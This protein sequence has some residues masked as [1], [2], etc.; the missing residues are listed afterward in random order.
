M[1]LRIQICF[2]LIIQFISSAIA[3]TNPYKYYSFS[4][5]QT[6][7]VIKGIWKDS[8]GYIWIATDLGV[9]TYDGTQTLTHARGLK[10]LYTKKFSQLPDGSFAVINDSGLQTVT[11]QND[12]I[13]FQDLTYRGVDLS[14]RM[15]YPKAIFVASDGWLWVGESNAVVRV[16]EVGLDR[17]FFGNNFNYHRSFS[18]AED[19][20]KNIWVAPY[21]GKLQVWNKTTSS[22]DSIAV[23]IPVRE[24]T[25]IVSVRGDYLLVGGVNGISMIKVDSDRNILESTFFSEIKGISTLK[26]AGDLVIIGTWDSGLYYFDY[27]SE[28]PT[29]QKFQEIEFNDIVD[30]YYDA[31]LDEIW[32]AGSENI[33]LL[34]RT[35]FVAFG[36]TGKYR[37]ES[38]VYDEKGDLFFTTGEDLFVHRKS[39]LNKELICPAEDVF[40]TTISLFQNQLWIGDQ[41]GRLHR[42]DEKRKKPVLVDSIP[43]SLYPVNHLNVIGNDLWIAGSPIGVMRL[44]SDFRIER[45][46]FGLATVIRKSPKGELFVGGNNA[47]NLLHVFDVKSKLFVDTKIAFEYEIEE[48]VRIEDIAFGPDGSIYL[49]SNEGVLVVERT[50]NGFISR[51]KLNFTLSENSLSCRALQWV[52]DDLWV[53]T[54]QGIY[55]YSPKGEIYFN[56]I[57]GLPSR[58]IKQRGFHFDGKILT[59]ATAQGMAKIEPAKV[60]FANTSSPVIE[61]FMVGDRPFYTQEMKDHID[62]LSNV[63]LSFRSFVYP[64]YDIQYQTRILGINDQWNSPSSNQIISLF[65][66]PRGKYTLEIRSKTVGYLWSNVTKVDFEVMDPWYMTWWAFVFF[67]VLAIAIVVISNKI[68]HYNLIGNQKKL[69]RLVEESTKEIEKHQEEIIE[70]KNRIIAQKEELLDKKEAV[71]KA[72]QAMTDTDLKYLKIRSNIE[73]SRSPRTRSISFKRMKRC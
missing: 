10:N 68:Y 59:V 60:N 25:S 19:A 54:N 63:E 57:S 27:K 37:I 32:V 44:T 38:F 11:R 45:F 12:S 49:A 66:I 56:T 53:G 28:K 72:Q 62:H 31:K 20:F 14:A 39:Q 46:N 9:L 52:G 69:K 21:S 43:A 13:L 2:I 35:P 30:L 48:N 4:N 41:Q 5:V 36:E 7:E 50:E 40:F 51:S 6:N 61:R 22:F 16:S 26:V 23:Q 73:T 17:H 47:A 58:I 33:A 29:F 3:Q 1:Q 8:T 18:F 24:S 55:L 65:G 67:F 34:K 64:G 70:Q 42:Y 15:N 71:F